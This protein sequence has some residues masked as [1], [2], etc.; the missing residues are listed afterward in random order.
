[1]DVE[2][3]TLDWIGLEL[4]IIYMILIYP[5]RRIPYVRSLVIDNRFDVLLRSIVYMDRIIFWTPTART[6]I[7]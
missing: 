5:S 3:E 1:M 2:V 6:H 7:F 4:H